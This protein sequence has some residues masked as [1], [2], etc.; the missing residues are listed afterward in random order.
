MQCSIEQ[1]FKRLL[2]NIYFPI[3][4]IVVALVISAII[5]LALGLNPMLAYNKLLAGAFGNLNAIGETF[6]YAVP[7]VFTGL[8][9]AVAMRSDM[10]NLGATGQLYIGAIAGGI[11][12]IY[13][14][15]IPSLLHILLV[16]AVGFIAGGLYGMIVSLLKSRYGASELIVTIMMN[17]I[18]IYLLSYCVTGPMKDMKSLNNLPQSPLIASTAKL[19]VILEG[20]RLHVGVFLA[21]GALIFFYIFLWRI[22]RGYEMRVVGINSEAAKY[23]GINVKTNQC[24]AMFISGGLAGIAGCIQIMSVQSR[25]IQLFAKEIG[26]NGV[27]VA[28][29]GGNTPIGIGVSSILF[30]ALESGSSKMQML[31]KVP[32]AVIYIIQSLVLMCIVAREMFRFKLFKKLK[33]KRNKEASL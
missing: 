5:M 4:A 25:L 2:S 9:F 22:P 20:T 28:L 24:L 13:V 21:I 10:I 19:P 18:A 32:N 29:L 27:A 16:L 8:S 17:Y 1:K 3:V 12:G 14:K 26:F 23:A 11:V 30:A 7:L 15:G 6:V 31:A 33:V